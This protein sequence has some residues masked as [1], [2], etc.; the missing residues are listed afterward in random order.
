M[1][2]L[3]KLI[4]SIIII[5][6]VIGNVLPS[7]SNAALTSTQ[8]SQLLG[9][10]SGYVSDYGKNGKNFASNYSHD[11]RND[12]FN[13]DYKRNI[14]PNG[15]S[16]IYSDCSSFVSFI[17]WTIS[18]YQMKDLYKN[19]NAWYTTN[20]NSDANG[21]K[22]Y[23]ENITNGSLQ[24]GDILFRNNSDGS[25]HVMIYIGNNQYVYNG[26]D[27]VEIKNLYS[28]AYSE[29]YR[30]KDGIIN[31][32][33]N[34]TLGNTV[35]QSTNSGGGN[36]SSGNQ[37]D[38]DTYVEPEWNEGVPEYDP[39]EFEYYGLPT[40]ESITANQPLIVIKL[41]EII[42][43]LIGIIILGIKIP[44]IGFTEIA[45]MIMSSG[46][47]AISGVD[48]KFTPNI[49]SFIWNASR[50][51][52]I[53][54]IVY[55]KV[56]ILNVDIFNMT[57]ESIKE[58]IKNYNGTGSETGQVDMQAIENAY[59]II[60][61]I[62]ENVAIW[63]N[64]FRNLVIIGMLAVLIYIGIR[65]AIS[66]IAEEKAKYKSMLIAWIVSFIIVIGIHYFMILIMELNNSF[67]SFIIPKNSIGSEISL[68]E[69]VRSRAYELKASRAIV[70]TVMYML[71]V[72][73]T[74]KFL[75]IYAKRFLAVMLLILFAPFTAA[76][77]AINKIKDGKTLIF[78]NWLKEYTFNVI[79]QG[80]HAFIY[81]LFVQIAL[82][83]SEKSIAGIILAFVLIKF[84]A[85]A[86]K[87]IRS[88]F[89]IR[90]GG[91][92]SILDNN[93]ESGENALGYFMKN[94]I[95]A[96]AGAKIGKAY[97]NRWVKP[98]LGKS[99]NVAKGIFNVPYQGLRAGGISATRNRLAN[100]TTNPN[101]KMGAVLDS[102][103]SSSMSHERKMLFDKY[104]NK[105][106]GDDGNQLF[107]ELPNW[108]NSGMFVF[109]KDG[110]AR[111]YKFNYS[112]REIVSDMDEYIA[113]QKSK[114]R[115]K[116][117]DEIK[118]YLKTAG[119]AII[120]AGAMIASIPLLIDNPVYGLNLFIRGYSSFSPMYK[121]RKNIR[122][123]GYRKPVNTKFK[124]RFKDFGK[125]VKTKI[126]DFTMAVPNIYINPVKNTKDM[127]Q[128]I[129]E[130]QEKLGKQLRVLYKIREKE[131]DLLEDIRKEQDDL[132]REEIERRDK[133][134]NSTS[135][136]PSIKLS[137]EQYN[138]IAPYLRNTEE[139]KEMDK[140]EVALIQFAKE[141]D[142][143][144]FYKT[145]KNEMKDVSKNVRVKLELQK[146][147]MQ[148]AKNKGIDIPLN[149]MEKKIQLVLEKGLIK[150]DTVG[151]IP[152]E[153]ARVHIYDM[154]NFYQEREAYKKGIT[155]NSKDIENKELYAKD[156][157]KVTSDIQKTA[158]MQDD[159]K[160]QEKFISE[161]NRLARNGT[162]VVNER[163]LINIA[164]D[165]ILENNLRK[166]DNSGSEGKFT[167]NINDADRVKQELRNIYGDELGRKFESRFD[168][169]LEAKQ[170]NKEFYIQ[171][172]EMKDFVK[173]LITD[174]KILMN[175]EFTVKDVSG[176]KDQID[177]FMEDNNQTIVFDDELEMNLKARIDRASNNNRN[178]KGEKI[179]TGKELKEFLYE[180][181]EEKGKVE[182]NS[183]LTKEEVS[184]L[185]DMI[186]SDNTRE[187]VKFGKTF[188]DYIEK[189]M[190]EKIV[191]SAIDKHIENSK[192][193]DLKSQDALKELE[194]KINKELQ[195][196]GY[197]T[198][199]DEVLKKVED[200]S[201]LRSSLIENIDKKT[202][203]KE[204][205]KSKTKVKD[206]ADMIYDAA[207]KKDGIER[208]LMYDGEK[209]DD[210]KV[211]K[212][213]D[214]IEELRSLNYEAEKLGIKRVERNGKVLNEKEE[215]Y[216][217]NVTLI[218][219]LVRNIMDKV[220][221]ET[222]D[223]VY[224]ENGN[225]YN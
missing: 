132:L 139:L 180:A 24:V 19:G 199:M 20:F 200:D 219:S 111:Y 81:S 215:E 190:Q 69:T 150:P 78:N 197:N 104:G 40:A 164:N 205:K 13:F 189:N 58:S 188:E 198:T 74:L 204:N 162:K 138:K 41:S 46:V 119:G 36:N 168:E 210:T 97:M 186:Q 18:N 108:R 45:E 1:K 207:S 182:E 208:D 148:Y 192:K 209:L 52:T 211:K 175:S 6:I 26:V 114:M 161:L 88:I 98:V 212:V 39:S 163:D 137:M 202:Y 25:R 134:S 61:I 221:S 142:S 66:T 84:M 158:G 129:G 30:L 64:I 140:L 122:I 183:I 169:L 143:S 128:E 43:Y 22:K 179:I 87:I 35:Y 125:N 220:K 121:N 21:S 4:I 72:W 86:D 167:V 63:Y 126:V 181:I 42:D 151:P 131:A 222:K 90:S 53:E 127:F 2:L 102:I 59:N 7:T 65:M 196:K 50:N 153:G 141:I 154:S 178:D 170:N 206:L 5:M 166:I 80:I 57:E 107:T 115:K 60:Y 93:L 201:K 49:F 14:M 85:D 203:E 68:Y 156:I 174:E 133:K 62:K 187:N 28:G 44:V 77:F 15:D 3:K 27:G 194:E 71:L 56:P 135:L 99:F 101:S 73:Y 29:V 117:A 17:Y 136:G 83:I 100:S 32:N 106:I 79:I 96:L 109:E 76:S 94:P 105:I 34:T 31:G 171:E 214:D 130:G 149:E 110:K 10:I 123:S 37:S 16:Y 223:I 160:F 116:N 213:K 12:I 82:N 103:A 165:L 145:L 33:L 173:D 38:G 146:F 48:N 23:F 216:Y 112:N 55:N 225:I 218:E 51:L 67:V 177:R 75:I 113:A 9:F 193:K 159:Y 54:N 184:D 195:N 155:N 70:G 152:K 124:Y 147:M 172:D 157:I 8:Q 185:V 11:E 144:R 47:D 92:N 118:K 224:D 91:K 176:L 217:E 95:N 191:S 89:K 120:G